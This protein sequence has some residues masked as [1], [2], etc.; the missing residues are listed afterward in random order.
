M[1]GL[2]MD[3][4]LA[5]D[6]HAS[7]GSWKAIL[8]LVLFFLSNVAVILPL[9]VPIPIVLLHIGHHILVLLRIVPDSH[10]PLKTRHVHLNFIT[11]PLASVLLL[12]AAGVFDGKTLRDG[13]VGT[14]GIQPLN[15]MAL[16]I[17]L[18]YI[19][20]SLDA[21]GLFRF[22]AFWVASKGG[23]SGRKLFTYLYIFFLVSGVVVG[24]DPVILSGTAFLAYF[25]RVAG[26][27]PP[28]AWI[29][30]QF[31][32]AN[33]A[34]VVLVSS[35]PTNLVLSGA[36]SV[37]FLSYAAHVV[38]PFLAASVCVYPLLLVL[39]RARSSQLPQPPLIPKRIDIGL[40]QA[41]VRATLV[42]QRGAIFGSVLLLVTLGVLVGVSTIGVPVW[43]VTVPPAVIMLLRDLH[44]D[45]TTHRAKKCSSGPSPGQDDSE[46]SIPPAEPRIQAHTGID[47]E[48]HELREVS[49]RIPTSSGPELDLSSAVSLPVSL[50]ATPAPPVTLLT[51]IS[52]VVSRITKTF[53][54]VTH[55]A[56]RLPVALLPFAFL[57]F[58]L[59]QG[60][61]TLGWVEL[62]A[63]W[64]AAWIARTG[65]LGAVGGMGLLSCLFCNFCGTNIGATI[66]LARVLQLWADAGDVDVD[67]RTRDGALYA[68]ALGSNFGAFTL[69]F[70]AS[71]AG[72]LWRQILRQKGI[73][74]RGQQFALVNAPI[75]V[76][77]MLVGC[78][79][80][81]GEVYV[82]HRG[83]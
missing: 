23:S 36:F 13:I 11:V 73:H 72:L 59:V 63:R 47:Q 55:I 41:E 58:I 38:L 10:T 64:W 79:V 76:V 77:A 18:A 56:E 43:E 62:F 39:F 49:S 53:P 50:K 27:T 80:L 19:S 78:A 24:N 5:T 31:A 69:T 51:L 81:V 75:S 45:W 52:P 70:S 26:I 15:I 82:E 6:P 22:L 21:T 71:L 29:F 37:S 68:L 74:V 30:S 48:Q 28:T 32:A 66:L 14:S 35:N 61:S 9:R 17:S 46:S 8:T 12:L 7:V 34:S 25:T 2:S 4:L 16:F 57:M 1:E 54:T 40:S 67:P 60:L 33:M 44:Y 3:Q 65:V 42:D 20:I 83:E